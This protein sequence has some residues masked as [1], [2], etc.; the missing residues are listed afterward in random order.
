MANPRSQS[1]SSSIQSS[2]HTL[3]IDIGGTGLKASV[4]DPTGKMV[5]DRVRVDTPHPCPPDLLVSTLKTLVAP[6]PPFD[7][8]S[9]GFPGVVR[10][11]TILTAANLGGEI[12]RGFQLEEALEKELG[13]PVRVLNDAEVQGLGIIEGIQLEVVIT[14]GTGVGSAIFNDGCLT[15]HLELA[16]HPLKGNKT[17]EE[18]L[19]NAAKI[20][21]GKKKWNKR[22][23]HMITVLRALTNFDKL[24]LG[25]GNAT[26]I[27]FDLPE[28]VVLAD[29]VAGITGGI[30]LWDDRI[31]SSVRS[32][33]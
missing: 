24:H 26:Q 21:V 32:F 4:L 23:E 8:V 9:V 5:A 12:F 31:W 27:D 16:H 25:G 19:G 11:G 2:A 18:Y 20:K 22:V 15:P 17:Y 7:R 10:H 3:A 30:R 1:K 13:K 28:K 33:E 29:N 6:L 14:L